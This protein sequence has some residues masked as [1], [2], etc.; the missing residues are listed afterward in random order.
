M[1]LDI[2]Y[3]VC[4]VFTS[5]ISIASREDG[6]RL[7]KDRDFSAFSQ[8]LTRHLLQNAPEFL[9]NLNRLKL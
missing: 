2:P 7:D 3:K 6:R 9:V 1:F 4:N 5:T 8:I